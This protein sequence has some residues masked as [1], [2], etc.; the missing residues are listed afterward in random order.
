MIDSLYLREKSAPYS[1]IIIFSNIII[2]IYSIWVLVFDWLL[3]T[4]RVDVAL[5]GH[6]PMA[7]DTA[8]CFILLS[9]SLILL[10][11]L[12]STKGL[13]AFSKLLAVGVLG[14]II[15][16]A[17]PS[18]F[19]SIKNNLGLYSYIQS[20]MSPH[21]AFCFAVLAISLI[22]INAKNKSYIKLNQ[23]FLHI[24][25]L[26]AFIVIMGYALDVP[27][28]HR[29]SFLSSMAIY[30]AIS[31]LLF[32]IS[33]AL[34]NHSIGFA[35]MFTGDMIGNIM[36][37]RLFINI[38]FAI[39]ILTAALRIFVHTFHLISPELGTA[40]TIVLFVIICLSL[41][42]KTSL[43]LNTIDVTRKIAQDN[44]RI[45]F[46]AAPYALVI[47][48]RQGKI[49]LVNHYTEILYGYT[50][51]ELVGQ[52]VKLII[53]TKMHDGYETR[54]EKFF[55][56]GSVV[57][58]GGTDEN[59]MLAINKN[60]TEFPIEIILI[61]IKTESQSISLASV[62]DITER[63]NYESIIKRQVTELQLKNKEL[64]QFNYITSHDLQEPLRTVL[65]YIQ[66]IEEE[67]REQINDELLTHLQTMNASVSRMGVIVKSLLEYGK[68]GTDKEVTETDCNKVVQDVL[69]DLK[70][71]IIATGAV[72]NYENLP[73]VYCYQ[74]ELRQL[75][76]NLINNAIKFQPKGNIPNIFIGCE[77]S[78]NYTTFYIK[79]NGLG[80]A[81]ENISKIFNIFERVHKKEEYEG[82]GI[83][84]A[85]CRKIVEMHRGKI[86]VDSQLGYGSTFIFTI[87]NLK[88]EQ[89]CKKHHAD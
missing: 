12:N 52:P 24:V 13:I 26:I 78:D 21:T 67:Y 84:L 30:A 27:E 75:F 19:P 8:V 77:K 82:H 46:D 68:I 16:Y 65:N 86:S 14:Y 51:E 44:F 88:N 15:F 55:E 3:K 41:I 64:E 89:N 9:T 45:A 32:S 69:T 70:S 79:D 35:G 34:V 60:G 40:L 25:T 37:R 50:K 6:L 23:G 58:M 72:I 11:F 36:A 66:Y 74:T 57:K 31:F 80:I 43:T 4:N 53:P 28:L 83:G 73:V 87:L 10:Q 59:E 63:R 56:I 20:G 47:S 39:I 54:R 5:F 1:T 2:I 29:F 76:Q 18:L 71:L 33:A 42:W 38:F 48:D 62:I 81:P 17:L 7:Y 85:N 61:P 22:G 49:L